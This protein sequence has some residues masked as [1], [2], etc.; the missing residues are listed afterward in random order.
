VHGGS[1]HCRDKVGPAVAHVLHVT[2]DAVVH[3]PTEMK[4]VRKLYVYRPT[5]RVKHSNGKDRIRIR[6]F[7]ICNYLYR[8]SIQIFKVGFLRF[9]YDECH[10]STHRLVFVSEFD[11]IIQ[12]E[13]ENYMY[14]YLQYLFVFDLFSSL[15][16]PPRTRRQSSA[17]RG[18]GRQWMGRF[19]FGDR[20]AM[21]PKGSHV[22]CDIRRKG[23]REKLLWE[24]YTRTS[25]N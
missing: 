19:V 15:P 9:K 13:K 12:L 7:N 11:S 10:Y 21:R 18:E 20:K 8:I 4:V 1:A 23:G 14:L 17:H 6:A 22:G 3:Y 16:A 2:V 24:D 5:E 25:F